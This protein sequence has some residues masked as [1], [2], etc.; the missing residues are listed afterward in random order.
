MVK[1]LNL[2][3]IEKRVVDVCSKCYVEK[4]QKICT[5]RNCKEEEFDQTIKCAKFDIK[6]QITTLV[7]N[8]QVQINE[9]K[10]INFI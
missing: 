6:S 3:K 9:Y 4:Q 10:S 5:S 1:N 8:Y 7:K 2:T